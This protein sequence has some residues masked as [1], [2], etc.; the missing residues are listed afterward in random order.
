MAGHDDVAVLAHSARAL[1]SS[2]TYTWTLCS[3]VFGGRRPRARRSLVDGDD[4][5]PAEDEHGKER[6]TLPAAERDASVTVDHLEWSED[7][8]SIRAPQNRFDAST[9][10][11][12]PVGRSLERS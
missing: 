9:V 3:A 5:L 1:R 2:D 10:A 11:G 12:L 8:N 7:P 6:P 4:L